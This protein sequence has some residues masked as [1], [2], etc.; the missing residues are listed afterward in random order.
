MNH[1]LIRSFIQ[2]DLR[3]SGIA[4]GD[5][6]GI[7]IRFAIALAL[8]RITPPPSSNPKSRL[9]YHEA[10]L[11]SQVRSHIYGN[12]GSSNE[13]SGSHRKPQIEAAILPLC[14]PL[15]QAIGHRM[16]YDTAIEASVD[17]N[18]IDIYLSSVILS[19]PAWYS[20]VNDPSIRLSRSEQLGRQLAACTEGVARLDEWLD[21]LEVEPYVLAPIVSDE[22]WEAYEQTLETFEGSQDLGIEP[23]DGVYPKGLDIGTVMEGSQ[24][25]THLSRFLHSGSMA[26]KL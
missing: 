12:Q 19:D 11:I 16:A 10:A 26:A 6:L 21:K 15:I 7:S 9:A 18:L 5:I 4:E 13:G 8:G 14:V 17:Q 23:S 25:I 24:S 3:G 20:E 1:S 22:K 2:S